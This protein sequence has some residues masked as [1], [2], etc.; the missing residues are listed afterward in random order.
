MKIE[1]YIFLIGAILSGCT[2]GKKED[3][4]DHTA[5]QESTATKYTCPMHPNVVQDGPGT[6]PVCGMDLVPMNATGA[7][8]G[9]GLMLTDS[10]I[11]LANITTQKVS[12]KPI[13]QTLVVNARLMVDEEKTTIISSRTTG[14]I[15]K[16]FIKETGRMVKQGEPLY[17]IYSETLLTLQREYLLALEQYEAL[18][19]EEKRYESFLKAA[20]SKL[21]LYGLNKKQVEQLASAKAVQQRITF[22]APA[23]GIIEEIAVAEG[24]YVNEG[25]RLYRIENIAS[26]WLEAELYPHETRF[27]KLGDKISVRA[28]GFESESITATANFL[29]PEYRAN[30]QITVM[31]AS[32]SNSDSR[33]KPGMQAQVFFTHSSRKA[34]AIPVDA[35]IRDGNGTHV[36]VQSEQNTFIPRMVKIGVEDFEQVEI[37]SGLEENE[38]VAV[39]GA[40]LLYSELILKKGTDPMAGH[41]H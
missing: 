37:I 1:V 33:F 19:K 7:N 8:E 31:R 29:S 13:G 23:G 40:Y 25:D 30:S 24:Q 10:Q 3:H 32:L 22:L 17:E 14:R 36:Y 34:L 28:I 18:G 27:V 39:S 41:N 6:C 12:V 35:I 4:S 16:L 9:N 21:L 26:L 38:I 5:A 11:K 15:E 20:E 2:S